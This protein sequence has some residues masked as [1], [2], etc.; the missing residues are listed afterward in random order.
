MRKVLVAPATLAG[1]E[2]KYLQVLRDGSFETVFPERA[3]QLNE[4]EL[5]RD[6]KG[7]SASLAGSEPY[8]RR[9]IAASPDL[10]VIARAGVGYDAVDVA[11]A[12]E[13]GIRGDHHPGANQDS[14]TEHTFALLL[15]L[16]KNVVPADRRPRPAAGSAAPRSPCGDAP[17]A[18]QVWAASARRWPCA[19]TISACGSSPTNRFPIR[20]SSNGGASR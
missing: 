9:V 18:S 1:V 10:R 6:L 11:A 7:I 2:A 20:P 3:V 15:A 17:S 16:A 19:R 5:L 14:V 8:T 13:H 4:E 12:T